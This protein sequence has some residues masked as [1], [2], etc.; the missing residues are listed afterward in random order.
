MTD[1]FSRQEALEKA[2]ELQE[3]SRDLNAKFDQAN[4]LRKRSS[5]LQRFTSRDR[6]RF[7]RIPN[8]LWVPV[9]VVLVVL[10]AI[11]LLSAGGHLAA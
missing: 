2:R 9:V 7:W 1:T 3:F 10:F 4:E 8:W 11:A 6:K 5:W